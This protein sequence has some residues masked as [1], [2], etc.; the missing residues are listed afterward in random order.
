MK[1]SKLFKE[2]VKYLVDCYNAKFGTADALFFADYPTSVYWGHPSVLESDLICLRQLLKH[3]VKWDMYVNLA[4]S[5]LPLVPYETFEATLKTASEAGHS[6]V[7]SFSMPKRDSFRVL[8]S[9]YLRRYLVERR[10]HK[11]CSSL[12]EFPQ[13]C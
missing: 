3:K 12:I 4:G 8:K 9:F 5:E 7:S 13:T 6:I 11:F 10:G 2:S 1:S